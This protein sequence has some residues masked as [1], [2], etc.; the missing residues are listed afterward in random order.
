[1]LLSKIEYVIHLSNKLAE[2]YVD[3]D[4]NKI[5]THYL[6]MGAGNTEEEAM[7]CIARLREAKDDYWDSIVLE[8]HT[9]EELARF[10]ST[11]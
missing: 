4:G 9:T 3:E 8:K 2:P 5:S 6:S 10:D 11:V 1:M 7:E